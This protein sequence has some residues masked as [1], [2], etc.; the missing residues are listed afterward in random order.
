MTKTDKKNDEESK[1]Y[2]FNIDDITDI[3][4]KVDEKFKEEKEK[5]QEDISIEDLTENIPLPGYMKTDLKAAVVKGKDET[6]ITHEEQCVTF[7]V[8]PDDKN[9]DF[10]EIEY[11]DG[12][13]ELK[14]DGRKLII[15]DPIFSMDLKEHAEGQISDCASTVFPQIAD[16][17]VQLALDEKRQRGPELRKPLFNYW[18]LILLGI[19]IP[20]IIITVML[21]RH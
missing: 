21:I 15:Y 5:K 17:M 20:V 10:A 3:E 14:K 9:A 4:K 8:N 16:E 11:K 13:T 6:G 12:K 19:M 1:D 18:W 7:E 2:S